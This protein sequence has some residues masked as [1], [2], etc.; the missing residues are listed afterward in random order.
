MHIDKGEGKL[1]LFRAKDNVLLTHIL[2]LLHNYFISPF[3]ILFVIFIFEPPPHRPL[4][5]PTSSPHLPDIDPTSTIHRPAYLNEIP[6]HFIR[7]IT[8]KGYDVICVNIFLRK[9]MRFSRKK[10]L[11]RSLPYYYHCMNTLT[12]R[13]QNTVFAADI[14]NPED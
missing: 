9:K 4:I 14:Q 8:T 3:L 12:P 7:E 2:M 13:K 10:S 11:I 1:A 5:D 6:P